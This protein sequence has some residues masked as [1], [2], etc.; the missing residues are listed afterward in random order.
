M[1]PTPRR[2]RWKPLKND[3]QGELG[4]VAT[5]AEGKSLFQSDR[6]AGALDGGRN[7]ARLCRSRIMLLSRERIKAIFLIDFM[8]SG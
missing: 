8:T 5:F 1:T 3:F 4:I 2:Q 7:R 6:P